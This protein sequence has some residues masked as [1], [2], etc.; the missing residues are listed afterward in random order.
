MTDYMTTTSSRQF[1]K[2]AIVLDIKGT[3]QTK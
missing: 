1:M 3:V 2:Y